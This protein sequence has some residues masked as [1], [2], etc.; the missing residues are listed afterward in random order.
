MVIRFR[1]LLV[2]DSSQE[3]LVASLHGPTK[4]GWLCQVLIT[5]SFPLIT[6]NGFT[7]PTIC[8]KLVLRSIISGQLPARPNS[9]KRSISAISFQGW[10]WKVKVLLDH[11]MLDAFISGA[12]GPRFKSRAGQIGYSVANSSPPLRHFFERRFVALGQ[13]DKNGPCKLVAGFGVIQ[14]VQW[15]HLIAM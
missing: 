1:E 12:G 5:Q 10:Q 14:R 8:N 6:M 13:W 7:T 3:L 11:Q 9:P 4:A 2:L 15:K